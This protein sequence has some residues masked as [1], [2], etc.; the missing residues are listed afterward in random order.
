MRRAVVWIVVLVVVAAAS[1]LRLH[2][3][4]ALLM[5]YVSICPGDT[6]DH[7]IAIMGTPTREAR[8]SL[9]E[10]ADY[11]LRYKLWLPF[12]DEWVVAFKG[13]VVVSK[14]YVPFPKNSGD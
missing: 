6:R 2:S 10:A 14:A 9:H 4:H 11:E 5:G 1:L 3:T 13:N 7:V 8:V 12:P